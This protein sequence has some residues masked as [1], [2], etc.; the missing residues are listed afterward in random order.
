[1][2]YKR[3]P[4]ITFSENSYCTNTR[5]M[6]ICKQVYDQIIRNTKP[7]RPNRN[8][9][10]I[11]TAEAPRG[12]IPAGGHGEGLPNHQEWQNR[13]LDLP[14]CAT[15]TTPATTNPAKGYHPGLAANEQETQMT[16][17]VTIRPS[18][19]IRLTN[20]LLREARRPNPAMD[21]A[22]ATWSDAQRKARNLAQ[23]WRKE[24]L[25]SGWTKYDQQFANELEA[26]FG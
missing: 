7:C 14:R 8:H 11:R 17:P 1:M 10:L 24:G 23:R 3:N 9:Q 21:D 15:A 16:T 25:R 5:F 13:R 18:R 20:R 2:W 12:S 22:E 19:P 4:L 26:A 6:R